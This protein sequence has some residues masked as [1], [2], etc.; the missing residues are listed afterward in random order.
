MKKIILSLSLV[1]ST[2]GAA[3]AISPVASESP[4]YV[5]G[6]A[7]A[8]NACKYHTSIRFFYYDASGN[9]VYYGPFYYFN[10]LEDAYSYILQEFPPVEYPNPP[11]NGGATVICTRE[12]SGGI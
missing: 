6:I 12:V 7:G 11:H 9:A 3:F 1:L 10:S 8:I 5:P 4:I 2:I